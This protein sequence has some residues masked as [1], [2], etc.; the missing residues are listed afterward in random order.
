MLRDRAP[1]PGGLAHKRHI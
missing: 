1:E